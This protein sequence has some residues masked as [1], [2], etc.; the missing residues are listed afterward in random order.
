LTYFVIILKNLCKIL[1]CK[2]STRLIFNKIR[3]KWENNSNKISKDKDQMMIKNR[4]IWCNNIKIIKIKEKIIK[5][6]HI[7]I[8]NIKIK[9]NYNKFSHKL[10]I[11][12]L[13]MLF[14]E[15]KLCY[16]LLYNNWKIKTIL[17]IKMIKNRKK[18]M[19]KIIKRIKWLILSIEKSS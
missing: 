16:S 3:N 19:K 9:I 7:R 14:K 8:T 17:L 1:I 13:L 5:V 12:S 4:G 6:S 10:L 18:W 15:F 2:N 11:L